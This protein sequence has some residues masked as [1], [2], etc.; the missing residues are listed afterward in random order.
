VSTRGD[1]LADQVRAALAR[2]RDID[3]DRNFFE[4]GF[5]SAELAEVLD[6]LNASGLGVVLL[7][8]YRHPNVRALAAELRR[9]GSASGAR[10]PARSGDLPWSRRR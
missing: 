3:L 4:A 1:D 7:D 5:S 8:L 6:R 9:R 10:P 2:Y